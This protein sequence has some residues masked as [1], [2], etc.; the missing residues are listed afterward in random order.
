MRERYELGT[1]P[2]VRRAL[3][4]R[5]PPEVAVAAVELITGPLLESPRRIGKPLRDALV[6]LTSARL[7]RGVE[8]ALR[9]RRAQASRGRPRHPTPHRGLQGEVTGAA[10]SRGAG[11]TGSGPSRPGMRGAAGAGPRWA[12]APEGR[13]GC[14]AVPAVWPGRAAGRACRAGSVTTARG[15]HRVRPCRTRREH[16]PER[17]DLDASFAV[18]RRSCCVRRPR[19]IPTPSTAC[20]VPRLHP[21]RSRS[22]SSQW[23]ASTALR[24]GLR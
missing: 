18:R 22:P 16:L 11:T 6:G 24:A 17:P 4:E 8:S 12:Q 5:L 9:D 2:P 20:S 13:A 15:A 1:A 19:E 7:G 3:A 21:Q 10:T 23:L 14:D